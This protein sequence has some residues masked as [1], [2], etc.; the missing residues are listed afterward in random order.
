MGKA[1]P[2]ERL[3]ALGRGDPEPTPGHTALNVEKA[4]G[5]SA[6]RKASRLMRRNIGIAPCIAATQGRLVARRDSNV[7]RVR[8]DIL[9]DTL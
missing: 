9:L 6:H 1:T 4:Q 7:W 3:I 2:P 8:C 5:C